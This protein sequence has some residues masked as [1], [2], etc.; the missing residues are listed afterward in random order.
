MNSH[1]QESGAAK[2]G[3]GP[4]PK[5]SFSAAGEHVACSEC[6]MVL[7]RW[8]M[9]QSSTG[10]LCPNCVPATAP[11]DSPPLPSSFS[12]STYR[13]NQAGFWIRAV[14]RLLDILFMGLLA[15]LAAVGIIF[16]A[17]TNTVYL[18]TAGVAIPVLYLTLTVGSSSAT[19][20]KR[21]CSL[22]LATSAGYP[23]GYLRAFWRI[24]TESLGWGAGLLVFK[25]LERNAASGSGNQSALWLLVLVLPCLTYLLVL[26]NPAKRGLHDYLAGTRVVKV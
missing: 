10:W 12:G 6:G 1:E 18:W 5:P 4:T 8:K 9:Q 25:Y 11:A 14:A 15:A 26:L 21:I 24:I 20:G 17:G 22:A 19:P 2:G 3:Q 7:P 23:V 16:A 13:G